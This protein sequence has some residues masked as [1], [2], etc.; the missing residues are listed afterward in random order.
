[1]RGDLDETLARLARRDEALRR[2][3]TVPGE[4]PEHEDDAE[5]A[6]S[7]GRDGH[8]AYRLRG[9]TRPELRD[10]VEE[11]AEAVRRVVAEH[12]GLAVTLRVEHGG[13][14]YPLR[15]SWSGPAVTVGPAPAP[16]PPPAWPMSVKTV[17]APGQDGMAGDPAARLAELIRRDP[18][19]LEDT[20][21]R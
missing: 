4:E 9:G 16:A 12:P 17:P 5:P 10:P 11:I 21:P 7:V 8:G 6:T 3:A 1:M 15:V 2:R 18:S 13:H 20:G 14:T 19:L